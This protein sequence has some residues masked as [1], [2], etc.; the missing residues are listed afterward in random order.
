MSANK[1]LPWLILMLAGVPWGATFTLTLIAIERG[2]HPLGIA[3]WQTMIGAAAL[4][5]FNALRGHWFFPV[6]WRH[7]L[8]YLVCGILGTA[9]PLTIFLYAAEH[10]QAGV[11]SISTA[12]VPMGTFAL[13]FLIRME[14]YEPLRVAGLGL[15]I[16]AIAMITLP[17][18][19]LPNPEAWIWVLAAVVGSNA[20]SV[21]NIVIAKYIPEDVDPFVT[22]AG[23]M[24]IATVLLLPITLLVD[25]WMAPAYPF[26]AVE[27]SIIAMGLINVVAYGLFILLVTLSGPVFAS[28]MGYVVTLAGVAWGMLV[29]G[30]RHSVWFWG[31]LVLMML[32]L[33]LVQPR[34]KDTTG[35]DGLTGVAHPGDHLVDHVE[36]PKDL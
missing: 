28:Q 31:A 5:I 27:W 12:T 24:S 2:D 9:L 13:A 32:G 8:F 15:G 4:L 11:L 6:S 18:T 22:L 29:F 26:Q 30:E 19:S 10:I 3:L 35:L 16:I 1:S 34:K 33:G 20:Y 17:E 7:F 23:I 21:E 36:P 14:K 25:G